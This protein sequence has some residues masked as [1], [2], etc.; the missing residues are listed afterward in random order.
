MLNKMKKN[1][2][3]SITQSG[4]PIN[5]ESL[6]HHRIIE[7]DRVE[8]K[9]GW[10]EKIK[11]SVIRSVCAFANDLLNNNGG[12]IILGIEEA[13]NGSPVL[14]PAGLDELNIDRIQ[15]EIIGACKGNISP[16]YLPLIFLETFQEKLLMVIWC[17]AGENRPY[18]SS[19]RKGDRKAYWVRAGS[20]SIEAVGDIR[21][22]LL[23]QT[24][25]IPF[26]D[27]RSLTGQL[28]DISPF[29]VKRFLTDIQSELAKMQ[30]SAE[31]IFEKLHLLIRVNDFKIPRNVALMFFND[32]P[33]HFFNSAR[34]E[35]AI[36][37]EDASGDLIEEKMFRGPFPGQI[38]SCL[39][40]L[41]GQFSTIIRKNPDQAEAEHIVPYPFV[42]VKEALVNAI[43]HRSY[44]SQ[45]EPVKVYLY[46][47]RI[48]IIN[49]PG[50]VQGIRKE[51]FQL[52]SLPPVPARNRRIGD[53]LKDLRLAEARG[54][55]IPKIQYN[56]NLIGSPQASFDFDDERTYF[57][58]ILPVNPR[59]MEIKKNP[60]FD[61]YK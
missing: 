6:I 33:E 4:L 24:A 57:R 50:P 13:A 30:L 41:Q 32:D 12:Y 25:K 58:V 53:F 44:D 31:D 23:E 2:K 19:I 45:P 16:A 39:N 51:H 48:E 56:M 9:S 15:R 11:E 54:T 43:Y 36:F 46:P 38:Q 20:S 17:P 1:I 61:I 10:N 35:V 14:P 47:N 40:Y 22:Q 55:G 42:A 3:G 49:Y 29:L 18:E 37:P 60:Q 27:R 59:F 28:E 5:L 26:D 52:E 8:F 34:I 21:R 7:N